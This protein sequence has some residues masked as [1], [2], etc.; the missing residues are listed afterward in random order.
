MCSSS[1]PA[2]FMSSRLLRVMLWHSHGISEDAHGENPR[3]EALLYSGSMWQCWMLAAFHSH[4]FCSITCSAAQSS[5]PHPRRKTKEYTSP[6]L[7]V[8]CLVNTYRYFLFV[9]VLS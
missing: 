8:R 5:N 9:L 4:K 7:A 6:V 1:V 2:A 3:Y